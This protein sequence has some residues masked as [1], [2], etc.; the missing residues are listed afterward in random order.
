MK[1]SNKWLLIGASVIASIMVVVGIW[2]KDNIKLIYE[3]NKY[4]SEE[5]QEDRQRVQE[6]VE[7]VLG[8]YELATIRELTEEEKVQLESGE[9]SVEDAAKLLVQ[10]ND[11]IQSELQSNANQ[12]EVTVN[13]E[14]VT[15]NQIVRTYTAKMYAIQSKY[16]GRL[17]ALESQGKKLIESYSSGKQTAQQLMPQGMALV[18]EA[19][20]LQ[21]KCDKEVD[22]TLK[23]LT[24]ELKRIGESDEVVKTIR[25]AYQL[26]KNTQKSYYLSMIPKK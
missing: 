5:I 14:E 20:D 12:E 6:E 16:S 25:S 24:K 26:E 2:Q 11:Q 23:R 18:K 19:L 22:E 8:R 4:T 13:Q 7:S 10:T 9:L 15:A 21:S 1:K 17:A 3:L